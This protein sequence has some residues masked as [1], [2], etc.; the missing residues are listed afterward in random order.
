MQRRPLMM[1]ALAL[2]LGSLSVLMVNN[3]LKKQDSG[4]TQSLR[5]VP[6]VVAA[7]DIQAGTKLDAL[8][9]KVVE[10]PEEAL[11]SGTFPDT[12]S[13]LG[14]LPPVALREMRKDE[15]VLAYKLSG[16]GARGGLI[17]RIPEDKRAISIPVNEISGV[18][19]FV[20]PGSF[21]DVLHTSAAGRSD[22]IPATR[23]LLQ[24]VP[25]IGIGQNSSENEKDPKL[26]KAVTLLVDPESGQKV[27]LALS[28]GQLSL[29]LRNDFDASLLA[30]QEITWR[31]LGPSQQAPAQLRVVKREHRKPAALAT[32]VV[33]APAPAAATQVE[34][35]RGLKV[36]HQTVT[37][38]AGSSTP[39]PQAAPGPSPDQTAR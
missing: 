8:M 14:P 15:L 37:D 29:L 6:V 23:V 26:V 21:V 22:D 38:T 2:V 19:G 36:T 25:V 27:A 35:V 31:D 10:W 5:T 30:T 34:M 11:P 16:Q 32:R 24:N 13:L 4:R 7:T 33:T 39:A 1:L 3:F 17:S 28:T 18:S 20:L 12:P 9:L